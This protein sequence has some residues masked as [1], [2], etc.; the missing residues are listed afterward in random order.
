M[1]DT[2]AELALKEEKV[3]KM[4]EQITMLEHALADK[5]KDMVD[6]E[7]EHLTARSGDQEEW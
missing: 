6:Q 3:K 7:S 5:E 1:E 4:N 2:R